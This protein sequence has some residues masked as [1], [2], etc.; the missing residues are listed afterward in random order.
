M[1]DV[2]RLRGGIVAAIEA[3]EDGAPEEGLAILRALDEEP[4]SRRVSCP[5][6]T[7]GFRWPGL[8]DRHLVISHPEEDD[9]QEQL[10][11]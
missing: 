11:A 1:S 10:A 9:E 7:L 5:H 2:G 4:D 6:C 8:L 3:F